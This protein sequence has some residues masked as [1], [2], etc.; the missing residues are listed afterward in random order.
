VRITG[1]DSSKQE[2]Q[3]APQKAQEYLNLD[4]SER[5]STTPIVKILQ[6]KEPISFIGFF[7]VF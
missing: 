1:N 5:D 2:K 3:M 4:A 7:Q 6:G